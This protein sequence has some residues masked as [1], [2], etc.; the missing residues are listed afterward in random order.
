M[1]TGKSNKTMIKRDIKP[2]CFNLNRA[3]GDFVINSKK[4][5]ITRSITSK[6]IKNSK[7]AVP[8]LIDLIDTNP[9]QNLH[10]IEP[11]RCNLTNFDKNRR[12]TCIRNYMRS[13]RTDATLQLLMITNLYKACKR[14]DLTDAALQTKYNSW[15][16]LT[17]KLEVGLNRWQPCLLK[18][19]DEIYSTPT[20]KWW[21]KPKSNGTITS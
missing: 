15:H 21:R 5:I 12:V 11:N 7:E 17:N 4:L 14:S 3:R 8:I 9:Y 6:S 1:S 19:L 13:S 16:I 18:E 10:E 2:I 20:P